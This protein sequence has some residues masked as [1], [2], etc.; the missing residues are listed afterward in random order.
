MCVGPC[1]QFV[2]VHVGT[3]FL[4]IAASGLLKFVM[5]SWFNYCVDRSVI[6]TYLIL[7]NL[8]TMCLKVLCIVV[9][10]FTYILSTNK[11]LAV[12]S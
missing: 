8:H 10:R 1:R 2:F 3:V 5:F 7:Q 4:L 11:I 6:F 12:V 9:N